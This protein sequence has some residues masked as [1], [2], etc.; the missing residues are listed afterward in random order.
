MH[1][2]PASRSAFIFS[3]RV[4]IFSRSAYTRSYNAAFL[5]SSRERAELSFT[6][7]D[8]YFSRLIFPLPSRLTGFYGFAPYSF[9]FTVRSLIKPACECDM[10][11]QNQLNLSL[12]FSSG[13]SPIIIGPV[14]I[15][16]LQLLIV[17]SA[18][19]FAFVR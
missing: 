1:T 14:A 12:C 18:F 13:C 4:N 8:L 11:P 3:K 2:V 6:P 19:T 9:T 16:P 7:L 5:P 10:P 17:P 15:H